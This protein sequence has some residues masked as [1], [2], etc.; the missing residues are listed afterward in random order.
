MTENYE[1]PRRRRRRFGAGVLAGGVL[2]QA[3]LLETIR[4]NLQFRMETAKQMV[5]GGT[6]EESMSPM[7]RRRQ[8]RERRLQALRGSGSDSSG[9]SPSG[10]MEEVAGQS[11]SG[12]IGESQ[13]TRSTSDT[14]DRTSGTPS[15]SEA[16][17]GTKQRAT[18][19]GFSS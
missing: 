3:N 13:S 15:M 19:R 16:N 6:A 14:Q 18:E 1:A 12:S 7:D 8:I 4:S 11:S 2:S 17:A 9:G 10:N 5:E